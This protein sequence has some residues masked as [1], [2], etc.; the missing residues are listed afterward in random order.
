MK[1]VFQH[2][3]RL[4]LIGLLL[5]LCLYTGCSMDDIF[6][7]KNAAS[8]ELSMTNISTDIAE[9]KTFSITATTKDTQGN[10]RAS[11]IVWTFS[12]PEKVS[13][14]H[15]TNDTISFSIIEPGKFVLTAYDESNSSLT[16]AVVIS[17][18]GALK[19]IY[20]SENNITLDQ[21]Q[22]HDISIT[23]NP[24]EPSNKDVVWTS[25]NTSIAQVAKVSETE[26]VI[27]SGVPGTTTITVSSTQNPSIKA[28][29]RVTVSDIYIPP[30]DPRYMR[31]S[32]TY[33]EFKSVTGSQ[34]ISAYIYDGNNSEKQGVITWTSSNPEIA[35]VQSIGK[36]VTVTPRAIGTATITAAMEGNPLIS[37]TCEVSIGNA[38]QGLVISK[39]DTGAVSRALSAEDPQISGTYPI[40][41]RVTYK[42]SYVPADT[43]QTGVKWTADSDS[44]KI[45][46][47]GDYVTVDT[48]KTGTV[49][50]KA[51]STKN[52]SIA[53]AASLGI[54]D[55]SVEPD[56]YISRIVLDPYSATLEE[57][58]DSIAIA[59]A[60]YNQDGQEYKTTLV[61]SSDSS[62]IRLNPI[63]NDGSLME[64]MPDSPG[65]ATI[66]VTA[67]ANPYVKTKASVYVLKEGEVPTAPEKIIPSTD[68]LTLIKG[69]SYSVDIAYLPVTP[70]TDS[71]VWKTSST[72][73]AEVKPASD[74]RSA[75]ITAI[76][77]GTTTITAESGLLPANP[78]TITVKVI[79]AEDV[80]KKVS[81]VALSDALLT[82]EPPFSADQTGL[83]ATSY[84]A[85]GNAIEDTYLWNI[86]N[87]TIISGRTYNNT[88]QFILTP[89]VPG[90]TMVTVQ[91]ASNP[92]AKAAASITVAGGL[93]SIRL[94][95]TSLTMAI[96]ESVYVDASLLPSSTIQKNVQWTISND[97]V[98]LL[99]DAVNP[100]R[101][102]VKGMK[103]GTSELKI[104]STDNPQVTQTLP[105]SVLANQ[106]K[107]EDPH[108]MRLSQAAINFNSI[109]QEK[110]LTATIHDGNNAEISGVVNWVS[111]NPDVVYVSPFGKVASAVAKGIGDA[112]ITAS[113]EGHGD[114]SAQ[115]HIT[116]GNPL[117]GLVITKVEHLS[118][119]RA[120][121]P[122][123]SGTFPVGSTA[124]YKVSYVPAD[125]SQT[126]V[127]WT[128]SSDII[129]ISPDG[130][131]VTVTCK[132]PGNALVTATST[133]NTTIAAAASLGIY[134]PSIEPDN[135]IS[136]LTLAPSAF[137]LRIGDKDD[138]TASIFRQ[139]ESQIDTDV[140]WASNAPGVLVTP[141][142]TN[143][144]RAGIEAKAAGLY[145]ITAK[146]LA[147]PFVSAT[148]NVLV[149]EEGQE[150]PSTPQA[151]IASVEG[152]TIVRNNRFDV[153]LTYLPDTG[154]TGSIVWTT[155]D[156]SIASVKPSADGLTGTITGEGIGTTTVTA[157]SSLLPNKP[158]KITVKVVSPEDVIQRVSNIVLSDTNITLNPPFTADQTGIMATSY[159]V[160]GN[161]IEDSFTWMIDK[162]NIISGKNYNGTKQFI[163]TPLKPGEATITVQSKNNPNATA[164][165]KILV[166]GGLKTITLSPSSLKLSIGSNV[167]VTASIMPEDT[168]QSSVSWSVSGD[169]VQMQRD[170]VNPY[171]VYIKGL[172][173]GTATLKVSSV[174]DPTINTTCQITVLPST[175]PDTSKVDHITLSQDTL[176]IAP[177]ITTPAILTASVF[178]AGGLVYPTG[179]EWEVEDPSI[180]ELSTKDDERVS[181]VAKKAG[182][183]RI[184][185]RSITDPSISK[186]CILT[187]SGKITSIVPEKTYITLVNGASTELKVTLNPT[188]TI[189]TELVWTTEGTTDGST[190]VTPWVTLRPTASGCVITGIKVG[191][192]TVTVTSKAR[193][194]VKAEIAVI[195]T[196]APKAMATIS[197]SPTPVE[198]SPNSNRVKVTAS[199]KPIGDSVIDEEV[200][201]RIDPVSLV[202]TTTGGSNEIYLI[203]N[204]TAGE[205]TIYAYLP[206]YPHIEEGKARL[207]VGGQLRSLD[208]KGSQSV[209]VNVGETV[210]IGVT[211]NPENTTQKGIIW[212]SSNAS[213]ARVNGGSAADAIVTGVSSGVATITATS[214][215]DASKKVEFTVVVK[216]IIN[217]VAFTD[218]Y[219]NRGLIFTTDTDRPLQLA[220]SISPD[221]ERKLIFKPKSNTFTMATLSGV[222]GTINDV[223]FTP[224]PAAAG[225]YEYNIT[226][227]N[228]V[229]DVLTI[230]T[231]FKGLSINTTREVFEGEYKSAQITVTSDTGEVS[232]EQIKW[233]SSNPSVATVS[234]TGLIKA[235]SPGEAIIYSTISGGAKLETRV[236]VNVEVPASFE[237]ALRAT[238]Y[239]PATGDTILPTMLDKITT[240]DL[241]QTPQT[242][243]IDLAGIKKLNNL[244]ELYVS[245]AKLSTDV[246]DLANSPYLTRVEAT[247]C[248]LTSVRNVPT[249]LQTFI[250]ANNLLTSASFLSTCNV[251]YVDLNNNQITSYPSLKIAEQVYLGANKITSLNVSS[252]TVKIIN[253]SS[254]R[255]SSIRIDS[256]SLINL[257]LSNN[258][259]YYGSFSLK[260]NKNL[261]TPN[262]EVLNLNSNLLGLYKDKS[263]STCNGTYQG[264]NSSTYSETET[265]NRI[266][267]LQSV[268]ITWL[269]KL[270]EL[271]L[272]NNH[273]RSGLSGYDKSVLFRVYA[274]S[275][276]RVDLRGNHIGNYYQIQNGSGTISWVPAASSYNAYG[277]NLSYDRGGCFYTARSW[278]DYWEWCLQHLTGWNYW[279][280]LK[281]MY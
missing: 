158:V 50:I 204:G 172:A 195:V 192:T 43:S 79:N 41:Q 227:D 179:V 8:L 226:Y 205:G 240:L 34:D 151:L 7:T 27:T 38:L 237:A 66:T 37:G 12:A 149:L 6:G 128:A 73:I 155:E 176:S 36:T 178:D 185:A 101:V 201:F 130:E 68:S 199:V 278:Y 215:Y 147:N 138:I 71:I 276:Q 268:S 127:N 279:I 228:K 203:P 120:I 84:D 180:A 163:L 175:L 94:N 112:V 187:V 241:R 183:T 265:Q 16:K 271:H 75:T 28:T 42:V 54:Y 65:M 95:P 40:G 154:E 121:E 269:P 160:S 258:Q 56:N 116:V 63:S 142:S 67:L 93:D 52:P 220:C 234:N 159:D 188:N 253:V 77:A 105:I 72:A 281:Y 264:A 246:L 169:A 131:Y 137:T 9:N 189:E 213:V 104:I 11:N 21:K 111:S 248:G 136:K 70:E 144:V 107:P 243:A 92:D 233:T 143:S 119:S 191:Q 39:V 5:T 197:I 24:S 266:Q 113:M 125:T 259:L 247:S 210:Q 148:A 235:V 232:T 270:K 35:S 225:T 102:T 62:S 19:A 222:D 110:T 168:V 23:F 69:Q 135:N 115:C 219:D 186:A 81:T 4:L 132:N 198:L 60:A 153:S 82:I 239:L 209:A 257:N 212:T 15:K 166:T 123:V 14:L 145:T 223:V 245:G 164:T 251:K 229:I 129:S 170:T 274:P 182:E 236:Y 200:V 22:T 64:V 267:P 156:S 100:L 211:Y 83:M 202:D 33:L 10:A 3:I 126:G 150:V 74:G 53:A 140:V 216:S 260:N 177:P 57:N 31:L 190:Q 194:E 238:G 108:Y 221:I 87:S 272:L 206:S 244:K 61:W 98:S 161:V 254:N 26:A 122:Q 80:N 109:G 174:D 277:I 85:S 280:E 124:T 29:C 48:A 139:D 47:D 97:S 118:K 171:K 230:N 49:L 165:A 252:E 55:P 275:L 25:E 184:I 46:P 89:L 103:A 1:K 133:R 20:I 256:G 261:N 181:I 255:I 86:A 162:T 114:I 249:G 88:K 152:R 99:R 217:E 250:A 90:T 193:P 17:A 96:G 106:I 263:C 196:D 262:L 78:A 146:A 44:V 218:Q 207:F 157:T 2:P 167:S 231:Q 91:S 51:T 59:A 30:T 32:T 214:T 76:N 117:Q 18:T 13:V 134:D 242:I 173:A 58:G 273:I 45:S 141:Y 224:D 208:A